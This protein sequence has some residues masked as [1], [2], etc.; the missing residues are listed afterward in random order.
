MSRIRTLAALAAAATLSLSLAGCGSDSTSSAGDA[1]QDGKVTAKQIC[2][3]GTLTFGVE[4]YEDP[5]N[6]I[7]AYK[8]LG[9]ELGKKLGCKVDVQISDSYVAEIVAMQNGKLDIGQFGPL[10]YVFAKQQ[11]GAVPLA[12][13]A[14]ANGEASSYTA[15]IWVK[16]G[17]PIKS[18]ADLKGHTLALGE[19]GSTSGD[20][21]PRK[22]LIDAGVDKD[23]KTAYAGGHPE[24]LESLVNGKSDA[25]EIN[26]Q[27]QASATK[28]GK[29]DASGYTE[30]WKSDPILNDPIAAGP[31]MTPAVAKAVQDALLQIQGSSVKAIGGYLDFTPP[32]GKPALVKVTDAD[33]KPLADLAKSL[34]LT[35]KDL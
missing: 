27:T 9:E 32:A 16:K 17:S 31:N 30:I 15:G 21:E 34:H 5:S 18:V 2:P 4:P 35:S 7:P 10:G 28:E 23:V 14:D 26:S 19:S 29:F 33:Y 6:L 20:A 22:A 1:P 25:A 12:S 11:A 3:K 13:F 24:A 8:A